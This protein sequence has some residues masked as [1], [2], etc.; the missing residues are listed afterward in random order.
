MAVQSR[1][2]RL[3]GY[4]LLSEWETRHAMDACRRSEHFAR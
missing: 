3:S 4:V 1:H 2:V